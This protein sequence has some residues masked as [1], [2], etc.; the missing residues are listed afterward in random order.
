MIRLLLI[1]LAIIILASCSSPKYTYNFDRYDYNSGR[2]TNNVD[3]AL[4]N[5]VSNGDKNPLTLDERSLIASTDDVIVIPEKKT[6]A[7]G[8]VKE[9]KVK[10]VK[11]DIKP[12]KTNA[13][14]AAD[15]EKSY[16]EM[17]KAQRKQFRKAMRDDMRRYIIPSKKSTMIIIPTP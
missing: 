10:D 15:L 9:V 17:S 3:T 5:E 16:K 1:I 2:K 11:S 7:T 14:T 4:P 13:P 6:T 8:D 12:V